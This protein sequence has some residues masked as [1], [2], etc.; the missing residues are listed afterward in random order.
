MPSIKILI[1][2]FEYSKQVVIF[3]MSIVF[4][5]TATFLTEFVHR[6]VRDRILVTYSSFMSVAIIMA[7][8]VAW[9]ILPQKLD[10]VIVDGYFGK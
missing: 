1:S 5:A 4:T 3:R 10:F 6:D 8:L 2:N 7:A 9:A